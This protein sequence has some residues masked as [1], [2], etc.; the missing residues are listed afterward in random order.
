MTVKQTRMT[1]GLNSLW[2]AALVAC[3]MSAPLAAQS[4]AASGYDKPPKELLDVLHAPSPPVPLVSPTEDTILLVS[5]QDY[6]SITRVAT[7]F[8][9]LAGVRAEPSNHSRHD[10]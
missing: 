9:R 7:P 8:L 3:A 2:I 1:V 4:Q 10:T 5:W 6:P